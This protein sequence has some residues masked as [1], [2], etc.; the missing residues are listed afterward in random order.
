M[1][2]I[3]TLYACLSVIKTYQ[4]MFCDNILRCGKQTR[5]PL[6]LIPPFLPPL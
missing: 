1:W 4:V 3:F 5:V 2:G 6:S